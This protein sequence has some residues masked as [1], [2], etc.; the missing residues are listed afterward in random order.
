MT[1]ESDE[2]DRKMLRHTL[3]TLAYRANK[4]LRE[5]PPEFRDFRVGDTTRTPGMILAHVGDLM[6]WAIWMSRGE[7]RW[8]DSDPLA[9]DDEVDRFFSRVA[10]LDSELRERET[11]GFSEEEIFQ[12]PIADALTHV[13]QI[14]MLRR[15]A[16]SPVRGENYFRAN[17]EIGR[18]GRDQPSPVREFD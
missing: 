8:Q 15:L 12:G 9:W 17:I 5:A 2:T 13:G 14:A 7:Y 1:K 3:A 4:A 11:L 18:V 6:D 16:G 10:T